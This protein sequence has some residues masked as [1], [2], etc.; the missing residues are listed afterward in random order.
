MSDSFIVMQYL[1][2][3]HGSSCMSSVSSKTGN[4]NDSFATHSAAVSV[5]RSQ[6]FCPVAA[7]LLRLVASS[8][9]YS[10][11]AIRSYTDHDG[12]FLVIRHVTAVAQLATGCGVDRDE[13]GNG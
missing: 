12:S 6:L 5:L 8:K 10:S 11:F 4:R 3:P 13:Q 2:S 7:R 9:Y 1:L